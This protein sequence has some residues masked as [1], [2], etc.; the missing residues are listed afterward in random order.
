MRRLFATVL[1]LAVVSVPA[2]GQLNSLPV[3]VSPKGGS[4]ITVALDYGR[5]LNQESDKNTA[6]GVRAM[7]GLGP[8]GIGAGIGT[9]NP[10]VSP[11]QRDTELQY[12]VNASLRLVGGALVPVAINL[13]GGAGF[14]DRTVNGAQRDELYI[15]VGI[16]LALNLPTPGF[17]FEPWVAPRVS[18][19]RSQ[20]SGVSDYQ[21]GFGMS[22]GVGLGFAMGLGLHVAV[23]WSDLPAATLLSPNDVAAIQP[24]VFGIGI[25]YTFRLPGV[26]VPPVPGR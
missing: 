14:L 9:V 1:C 16:G 10:V 17:S 4:G 23:D 11:N 24:A 25:N 5:G 20:T 8:L 7:L 18:V 6:L 22:A 15:P 2:A 19:R 3:M 21:T 12:M 13:H 26:R